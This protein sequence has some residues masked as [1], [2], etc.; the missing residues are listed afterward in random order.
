[1]EKNDL[2]FILSEMNRRQNLKFDNKLDY[3]IKH[4]TYV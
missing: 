1:M 3:R 2:K 4:L